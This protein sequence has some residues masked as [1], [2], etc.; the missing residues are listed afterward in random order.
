VHCT[1][2]LNDMPLFTNLLHFV[3]ISFTPRSKEAVILIT[4]RLRKTFQ[5]T[6]HLFYLSSFYGI[7]RCENGG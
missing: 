2:A 3:F 4:E 6:K 5:N 7:T 1:P